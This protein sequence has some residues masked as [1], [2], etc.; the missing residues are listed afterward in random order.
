LEYLSKHFPVVVITG[1]RQTGKTTLIKNVKK[2]AA[3]ITLDYPRIR[4]LAKT[5][6]ELFLQQYQPPLIIDEIQYAPELLQYIKI[7]VDDDRSFGQ[8]FLTG[9]QMFRLMKNVSE[10]LAGRVGLLSLYG[11]SRS[12]ILNK[13]E[14]PFLPSNHYSEKAKETLT[15]VFD[16]IY[17]GGMPQMIT[18]ID[19]TP[20][21]YFGEYMQTYLERDI[22]DLL[23]IKNELKFQRFISCLAI[24]TG[25]ELNLSDI[26]RDVGIDSKTAD[27][28]YHFWYPRV[29]YISCNHTLEIEL[30]VW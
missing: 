29:L 10:S 26:G 28:W 13:D 17:R 27:S 18:D 2:D 4:E 25:Q 8:Y 16:K 23:E 1:A 19:L 7:K 30:N 6:P 9:S 14:T 3:Y 12:E 5:D 22:R 24:R 11:L 21:S 20:E 15:S